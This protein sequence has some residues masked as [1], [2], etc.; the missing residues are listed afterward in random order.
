MSLMLHCGAYSLTREEVAELPVVR[1]KTDT[2][3]TMPFINDVNYAVE[4]IERL[5]LQIVDEQYGIGRAGKQFFGAIECKTDQDYA[6][7]IGLRGSHDM[8]LNRGIA[9]GSRVFVCDNLSFSGDIAIQTKQ[10]VNLPYR[11]PG[12]IQGAIEQVP[13]MA[14]HQAERFARYKDYTVTEMEGKGLLIDMLRDK[15]ITP[16]EIVPIVGEWEKPS[17]EEHE[18]FG[19]SLWRLH[20]AVTEVK[21]P[22][23]PQQANFLRTVNSTMKMTEFLDRLVA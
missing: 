16:R 13:E 6:L 18:E 1:P 5:G 4:A 19:F 22:Q 9:V 23:R 15:I 10:T 8:S 12:L 2:H 21:R 7:T 17:H 11:L 14:E 20:N 3:S